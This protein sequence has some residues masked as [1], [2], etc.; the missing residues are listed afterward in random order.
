[1]L[2]ALLGASKYFLTAGI[3]EIEF[4]SNH[5]PIKGVEIM[6]EAACALLGRNDSPEQ[7]ALLVA[8]AAVR[9]V[10]LLDAEP[11]KHAAVSVYTGD[12]LSNILPILH[13]QIFF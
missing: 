3:S 4:L 5:L 1:V 10:G 7:L 2:S 11:L 6:D 13:F 12:K 8:P 9:K